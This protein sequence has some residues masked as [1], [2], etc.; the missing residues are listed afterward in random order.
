MSAGGKW[1]HVAV[2]GDVEAVE[3]AGDTVEESVARRSMCL[4]GGSASSWRRRGFGMSA[5]FLVHGS[6]VVF[7]ALCS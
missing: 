4:G 2:R 6:A 3:Q 1:P 5:T 7:P